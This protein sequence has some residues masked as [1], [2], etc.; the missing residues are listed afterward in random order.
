MFLRSSS[1]QLQG[2][3]ESKETPSLQSLTS[4]RR[5]SLQ[6]HD[7][8]QIHKYKVGDIVKDHISSVNMEVIDEIFSCQGIGKTKGRGIRALDH[9][10]KNTIFCWTEKPLIEMDLERYTR[11]EYEKNGWIIFGKRACPLHE[12]P[13]LAN[14]VAPLDAYHVEQSNTLLGLGRIKRGMSI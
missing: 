9:V 10:K 7:L 5:P 2:T 6:N 3:N 13:M 1:K 4:F 8:Y 14:T 12:L 11:N